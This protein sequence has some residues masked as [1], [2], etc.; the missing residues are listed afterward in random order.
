[1]SPWLSD[2]YLSSQSDA[3]LL[4]LTRDGQARAFAILTERYRAELLAHARRLSANGSAEDVVQQAF[5]NA[6]AAVRAGAEVGHPRGWLHAI[7]RHAAMRVR[8]SGEASLEEFD[9]CGESLEILVERRAHVRSVLTAVDGLPT[10]QRQ[11]LVGSS[12]QGL[13][14][15]ELSSSL[16]VSEGAVRQ[17][18]HRARLAL[19]T[20]VT[21][22]TPYPLARWLAAAGSNSGTG[23]DLAMTAGAASAG[24]L[25][26][27]VG[28][29]AAAGAI[30]TGI[31]A[32]QSHPAAHPAR[33][34][35]AHAGSMRTAPGGQGASAVHTAGALPAAGV[36][37]Y[38]SDRVTGP[39][40]SATALG[41][42]RSDSA[43]GHRHGSGTRGPDTSSGSRGDSGT[44]SGDR[45]GGTGTRSGGD[46]G[47]NRGSAQDSGSAR[48]ASSD[49]NSGSGGD[50]GSS[51]GSGSG[52]GLGSGGGSGSS[53]DSGSGSSGGSGSG[54]VSGTPPSTSSGSGSS[55]STNGGGG[56]GPTPGSTPVV[57]TTP[58]GD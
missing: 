33:A 48:A 30:A 27:K 49:G 4:S 18:V 34:H 21:A 39:R 31:A 26:A 24:G 51:S 8:P 55:G 41:R 9:A 5:L 7:L 6:F 17:L 57:D 11:A 16:G 25:M 52:S 20:A 10:R 2:L 53:G 47:S 35:R 50:S 12:L 19:R 29:F 22:L 45:S 46:G 58:T 43:P 15:T 1:M 37:L 44:P 40:S 38:T 54:S 36:P 28:V 32:V 56:S 14:R 3:R 23:S 42:R 13:S